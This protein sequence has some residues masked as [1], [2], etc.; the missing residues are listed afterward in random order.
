MRVHPAA[1]DRVPFSSGRAA[2]AG[3][4]ALRL[5]RQ[6]AT[7]FSR[8]KVASPASQVTR[9]SEPSPVGQSVEAETCL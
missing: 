4:C 7:Y 2:V 8:H 5:H 1:E 9:D 3:L 6:S